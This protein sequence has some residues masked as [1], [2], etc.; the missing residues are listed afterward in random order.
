MERLGRSVCESGRKEV[1]FKQVMRDRTDELD[2]GP[3]QVQKVRVYRNQICKQGEAELELQPQGKGEGLTSL[4]LGVG[5]PSGKSANDY[6]SS[7]G[8][9]KK[10]KDPR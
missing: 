8:S 2:R 6:H 7:D 3:Q 9:Q 4:L 5:Q 1:Y 10:V